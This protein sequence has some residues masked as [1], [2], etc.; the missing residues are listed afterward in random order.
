MRFLNLQ[1]NDDTKT[2]LGDIFHYLI[3][4]EHCLD[5]KPGE[6]IHVERFGDI[7]ISS[8]SN[9]ANMEI[10]HHQDEHNL[11]SRNSDFWKSLKNWVINHQNMD[12]FKRL[13]LVSTSMTSEDSIFHQWNEL[14]EEQR[15]KIIKD[16]GDEQKKKEESFRKFYNEI[17]SV[18]NTVI[19]KTL[20]KLELQLNE[21]D[22]TKRKD[23][24]KQHP[25]FS[26]IKSGDED[27]FIYELLGSILMRPVENNGKWEISH[28]EYKT[29]ATSIRDKQA[30]GS[31][32]L[33]GTYSNEAPSNVSSYMDKDFVK[34]ILDIECEDEVEEAIVNYWRMNQTYIDHFNDDP[35]YLN[36]VIEYKSD[37]NKRLQRM[38]KSLRRRCKL[39]NYTAV[40]QDF[41]DEVMLLE[42][43]PFG[44]INPNRDFFQQ[45]IVHS[46]VDEGKLIWNLKK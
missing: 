26:L 45:G 10:K 1:K 6:I 5:L 34:E 25:S 39:D 8:E 15:F 32:P 18:E 14:N 38:R 21:K 36:D 19:L 7:A 35:I 16:E 43:M 31:R 11:S 41:F 12:K 17:F 40:S 30:S 20:A 24:I 9:S 27:S 3:V 46:I 44:T 23:K 42:A 29:H 22:I 4:L 28:D 13:I 2:K 33:P 37:L